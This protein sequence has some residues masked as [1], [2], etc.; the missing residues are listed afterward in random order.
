LIANWQTKDSAQNDSK[1]TQTKC[2][3]EL[4]IV[5]TARSVQTVAVGHEC[6]I[7]LPTECKAQK[8]SHVLS[9]GFMSLGVKQL[10]RE[11]D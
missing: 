4:R 6:L 5:G 1:H 2:S 9:I 10:G 3:T 7:P 11:S 8:P